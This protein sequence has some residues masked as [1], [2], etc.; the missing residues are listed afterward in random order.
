MVKGRKPTPA[1]IKALTA[2]RTKAQPPESGPQFDAATVQPP[3][4]LGKLAATLWRKLAPQ[5]ARNGLLQA[6]DEEALAVYCETWQ[7]YREVAEELAREGR[8]IESANGTTIPHPLAGQLSTLRE[9]L[10]KW[11]SE[12]GFT[13]ASRERIKGVTVPTAPSEVEEFLRLA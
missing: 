2:D 6:V 9:H 10:R 12:F 8:T 11:A 3:K 7:Q 1:G 13:P 4:H 5:L